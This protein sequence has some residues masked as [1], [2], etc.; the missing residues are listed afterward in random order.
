[1]A[2]AAEFVRE[3]RAKE[4]ALVATLALQIPQ[5]AGDVLLLGDNEGV[6]EIHTKDGSLWAAVVN[7]RRPREYQFNRDAALLH[8]LAIK[9]E[10]AATQA[11][12]YAARV[13]GLPLD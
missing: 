2:A 5:R 11:H 6:V 13:I 3:Q 8:L 1:M 10:S 4:L 9:H 7:G 12:I